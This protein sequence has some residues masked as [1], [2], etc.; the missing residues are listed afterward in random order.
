MP[1]PLEGIRVLDLTRVLAGP[2]ATLIM[3]DLGAEV[4]KIEPHEGDGTRGKGETGLGATPEHYKHGGDSGYFL[5]INRNKKSIVLDFKQDA[6]REIFTELA[7]TSDVVIEN[8]RPGVTA[9]LGVDYETVKNVKPDIVYCSISGYGADGPLRDWP[10]FDVAVQAM[11]GGMSITGEPGRPPCR[12]GL[13]IGDLAGGM[14]AVISVLA[15]LRRRDA[16]GK[17]EWIDLSLLDGQVGM[18]TYVAAYYFLSGIIPEPIGSGHQTAVPYGAYPTKDYYMVIAAT[19]DRFW[20]NLCRALDAPEMADEPGF[21]TREERMENRR[22]VDEFI[23]GR[24]LE[25]T[26]DE[27]MKAF[28]EHYVPAAPVL[29]VDKTMA[30]EQVSQRGMIVETEHAR[31]GTFKTANTPFTRMKD[32][33]GENYLRPP[34]LGEHTAEI[35]KNILGYSEEKIEKL[36]SSGAI[37]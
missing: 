25:R 7:K 31:G 37:T 15:A 28:T 20:R 29:T 30:L 3:G 24:T 26:S 21:A 1:P 36:R 10:A 12:A 5:S 23:C 17:G 16:T 9:R 11:G 19:N 6:A 14:F 35:L 13:P 34:L 27:W 22:A 4:I 33:S 32:V 8:F 2:Y 18:L